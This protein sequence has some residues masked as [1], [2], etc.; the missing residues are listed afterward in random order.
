[1]IF[2]VNE[3]SDSWLS[4]KGGDQGRGICKRHHSGTGVAGTMGLCMD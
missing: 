3:E 1:M 2:I 4:L